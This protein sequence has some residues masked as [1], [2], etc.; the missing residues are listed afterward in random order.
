MTQSN[1]PRPADEVRRAAEALRGVAQS[2]RIFFSMPVIDGITPLALLD[3]SRTEAHEGEALPRR[4]GI[5]RMDELGLPCL[6]HGILYGDGC[7]EGILI[8]DDRIFLHKEHIERFWQS[9]RKLDIHIPYT[10]EELTLHMLETARQVDF[11]EG[12]R[13]YI[14]LL[15]TRGLGDLGINP[16]KCTAAT[17]FSLTSTIKL[18]PG[19]MY[20]T[21]IELGLARDRRRPHAS[22]LDPTVKSNNYINNVMALIEGTS[23][24]NTLESLILTRDGFIAEATVD[25][26]FLI[27]R[28][29][30][31]EKDPQRVQILTPRREYCL[32]GITRALV[33]RFCRDA[34]YRVDETADILPIDLVGPGRECFMTGTG[35]GVMPIVRVIGN[36]IGDGTPG[37]I[38][39][40]LVQR[41]DKAVADPTCGL[42]LEATP[43][44]V[45]A[46]LNGPGTLPEE[47][48][49]YQEDT[50]ERSPEF[51]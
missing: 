25:N 9:A 2:A 27:M 37:P 24:W 47:I 23:K 26:L 50:T 33:L 51:A 1:V 3:E 41:I 44:E 14:R 4:H 12:S 34:G 32:N 39:R 11:P 19:E 49:L 18:Y 21:G 8:A 10:R 43:E 42:D 5:F 48:A 16:A 46:Y 28:E 22:V 45:R 20:E 30:G 7:F 17:L 38:T 15:M 29:P 40:K 36:N 13:G 31:W 35:A 6:D